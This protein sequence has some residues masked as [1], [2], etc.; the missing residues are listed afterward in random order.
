MH[1]HETRL[2][3]G[4]TVIA[5]LNDSVHSVSFGYYVRTGSR[6]ETADVAGV[7]HFLEHMAFK[8]NDR[9]T[10]DDINRRFDD[11]GADYN[12]STSEEVTTF[13]ATVLPEYL[14]EAFD[15]LSVVMRPVLREEDFDTEKQVILE[16][17]MMYQDQPGWV[18]YERIMQEHFQ[19]HPL[20]QSILGSLESIR[21]LP[22]EKM[23]EYYQNR[24]RTGQIVLAVAGNTT[25]EQVVQLATEHTQG[26]PAGTVE[27]DVAP[28]RPQP[29]KTLVIPR[30]QSVQQHVMA[31]APAPAAADDRTYVAQLLSVIVG[32]G[33][34]SR[35]YWDLVDPGLVESAQLGYYDFDGSGAWMSYLCCEPGDVA[36]CRQ[37]MTDICSDVNQQGVTETELE[38]A[39]SKVAARI[40]LAGERPRGRRGSLGENWLYRQKYRSIET[41][42]ATVQGITANDINALLE[43]YP[44]TDTTIATIG[45]LTELP[46]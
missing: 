3:N 4:L 17:I 42:L 12:A 11:I 2:D 46:G 33:V 9:Y 13:H 31:L 41:D 44:L 29:G 5:E 18:I 40:V 10:A 8:G 45:P 27:R 36:A 43:E 23:R 1:F 35:F 32:D 38:Q 30:E 19:G 25:W 39:R 37:R 16:E 15:L 20:S 7:S 6:D 26:W 28:A 21:D 34:S 14:P 22:V 24:Y